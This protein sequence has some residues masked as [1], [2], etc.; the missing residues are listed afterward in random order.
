MGR[1]CGSTPECCGVTG[2]LIISVAATAAMLSVASAAWCAQER[3]IEEVIVS[4]QRVE[5]SAQKVPI[6]LSAFDETLIK[7]RQIVGIL[8]VQVHAPNISGTDANFGDR[9]ISIRGVGNL[10]EAQGRQ[11]PSVSYHLNHVPFDPPVTEFYDL[12]R[13]EVL[14]GPQGTLY[15][16]NSTAGAVN[17]IT[18]RPGFDGFKG[19]AGLELGNY[20]LLRATGAVDISFSDKLAVRAAGYKLDRDGY[21]NNLADGQVPNVD[22]DVDGR[23]I[24]SFRIT[25]EWR[26]SDRTTTWLMYE[27]TREDDDRVRI[28]NQVCKTNPLPTTSCLP[29]E[30]GLEA[31]NPSANAA[32]FAVASLF[33]LFPPG[34]SDAS[35]GLIFDHP[36]PVLGIR[37]QHTDLEPVFEYEADLVIGSVEHTFDQMTLSI[38]GSFQESSYLSQQ[39]WYMDVGYTLGP[40][41]FNPLGQWPTSQTNQNPKDP[42]GGPCPIVSGAG[43]AA[44]G[45]IVDT[46]PTRSF[47][48]DQVTRHNRT[49]SIEAKLATGLEGPLNFLLGG[50]YLH[51]SSTSS[52]SGGSSE[53]EVLLTTFGLYPTTEIFVGKGRNENFS[54]FGEVYWNPTD[55]LQITAGLRYSHDEARGKG[56][57][58]LGT[59]VLAGDPPGW[60]RQTFTDWIDGAQPSDTALALADFYGVQ[61]RALDAEDSATLIAILQTIPPIPT[62][63]EAQ[64]VFGAPDGLTTD[65][66]SGRFAIDW[67]I[68]DQVMLYGLYSR[69]RN[70]G[71]FTLDQ[72]ANAAGRYDAETVDAFEIGAKSLLL[73][74]SLLLNASAFYN[75]SDGHHVSGRPDGPLLVEILNMDA[76]VWGVEIEA[77]WRPTANLNVEIGYG[78]LES[79]IDDFQTLDIVDLTQGDPGLVLL[80]DFGGSSVN[81]VAPRNDALALTPLAIESGSAVGPDQAPNAQYPDGIPALFSRDFLDFFGVETSNG[82]PAELDGN[83][84]AT[85]PEHSIYLGLAY[86]WFWQAGALTVRWDYYWQDRSYARVFNRRGDEIDSW[87]QH[88]ASLTFA[89]NRWSIK[90]WIRNISDEDNVTD[91]YLHANEAVGPYRNY[92]LTEPRVYGATLSYSFGEELD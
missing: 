46:E 92:F 21:I 6:S 63:G 8:D 89:G 37:D 64:A 57:G 38:L 20:D 33:N 74:G 12:V 52:L 86:T 67:Q 32:G 9:Q 22:G 90:A 15:G 78:W 7:D 45:C 76:D 81:Y 70:P 65:G 53:I 60:V 73:D 91:H 79:R 30:F 55:R 84:L 31:P 27:R 24:Y 28:H 62:F 88:N 66:L 80:R 75:V 11:Q 26:I 10:V 14:R 5:E 61:D 3:L 34:A 51:G 59:S 69:G 68:R 40:T 47:W 36:R 35:T 85:A 19:S 4:A 39:D 25:P 1:R 42:F 50:Q 82:V 16:R 29:D 58:G 54:F 44:S 41:P 23:D 48:Y 56:A 49:W 43:G 72:Q 18:K 71:G 83:A 77:R 17:A 13:L 2:R 87:D